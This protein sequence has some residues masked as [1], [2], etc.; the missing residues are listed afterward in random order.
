MLLVSNAAQERSGHH[1]RWN[2]TPSQSAQYKHNM[3]TL[4]MDQTWTNHRYA[5]KTMA[6]HLHIC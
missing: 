3:A 1:H 5:N 4:V 6:H 2:S